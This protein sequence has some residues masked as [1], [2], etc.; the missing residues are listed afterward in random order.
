[1]NIAGLDFF[2][3]PPQ[4]NYF[5]KEANQTF[6]GGI[7]FYLHCSNGHNKFNYTL[8]YFYKR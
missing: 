7:F 8:D 4:I 5:K 3:K 6:F 2:S 1:M